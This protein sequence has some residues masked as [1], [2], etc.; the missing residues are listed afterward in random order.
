MCALPTIEV[1]PVRTARQ[2]ANHN[3]FTDLCRYRGRFY[4]AFRSCPDGHS[5]FST[6]SIVILSSDDGQ[7]WSE[8]FTF[9]VAGRDTRDPHFLVFEEK[10]FV[11]SGTWLIPEGGQ[12]LNLN[13][14]VGY[15]ACTDDGKD[16]S[17]PFLM[18]GTYGHYIWRTAAHGNQA[19]LCARRRRGFE[20][21]IDD[22]QEPKTIES[23]MLES[24]DGRT[25]RFRTLFAEEYGDE[26]AF[27]FEADGSVLA[28][29]R[30][31]DGERARVCRSSSP[32]REWTRVPLD[33][34]VGG[35]LLSRWSDHYIVGGR[36]TSEGVASMNLY[37]LVDDQLHEVA[38]LPSGGDCSYPGFVELDD[39]RGLLSYYST[40]EGT[41]AIYL[42][43]LSLR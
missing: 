39:G 13:D 23:A 34:N 6:A 16:W 22:E 30:D 11:Y 20:A 42:T 19:Y 10:L 33:R 36:K 2:D 24:D 5:A 35:P 15:G 43:E 25:W 41:T 3:A 12:P 7:H 38:E 28:L 27:L 21:G 40:H 8:V 37:W 17:D 32:W 26:T 14:H 29:V 9:S 4:L 18:E 1:G 31:G